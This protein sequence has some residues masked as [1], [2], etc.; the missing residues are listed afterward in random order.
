MHF[1]GTAFG[2]DVVYVPELIYAEQGP[3]ITRLPDESVRL[4]MTIDAVS[5]VL[6]APASCAPLPDDSNATACVYEGDAQMT[7]VRTGADR[8]V[9]RI[10]SLRWES[11]RQAYGRPDVSLAALSAVMNQPP[12]DELLKKFLSPAPGDDG[13]QAARALLGNDLVDDVDRA[14]KALAAG[15]HDEALR[16]LRGT[17]GVPPASTSVSNIASTFVA[18]QHAT[19]AWNRLKVGMS[20]AEVTAI[21]GNPVSTK[22]W[23]G[24]LVFESPGGKFRAIDVW[25]YPKGLVGFGSEST[26]SGWAGE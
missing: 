23:A 4:G 21:L 5:S 18:P 11:G 16:I 22:G 10:S 2:A 12:S 20:A 14:Q 26:V 19:G 24:G 13:E 8:V 15:K 17:S 9:N 25:Y 1:Q 7:I 3:W 6:G